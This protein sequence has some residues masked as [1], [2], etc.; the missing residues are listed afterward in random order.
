MYILLH[1]DEIQYKLV[2]KK[3]LK[4]KMVWCVHH[5]NLKNKILEYLFY[6]LAHLGKTVQIDKKSLTHMIKVQHKA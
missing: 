3:Y 4:Q 5:V 2:S 6:I 1:N